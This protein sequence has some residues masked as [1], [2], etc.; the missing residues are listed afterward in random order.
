LAGQALDL[1]R[2]SPQID[3][4]RERYRRLQPW[5]ENCDLPPF[6]PTRCPRIVRQQARQSAQ[7]CA[8]IGGATARLSQVTRLHAAAPPRT[9][10]GEGCRP[11][12]WA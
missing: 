9:S 10:G 3:E 11:P 8:W 5:A 7:S 12:T 6:F 4:P 1:H 2:R